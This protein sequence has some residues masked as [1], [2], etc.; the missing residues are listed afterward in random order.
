MKKV[1]L[2]AVIIH[3]CIL[4]H[5]QEVS[6]DEWQSAGQ[7]FNWLDNSIWVRY[8]VDTDGDIFWHTDDAIRFVGGFVQIQLG[9]AK[10]HTVCYYRTDRKKALVF[11][12]PIGDSVVWRCQLRK[13]RAGFELLLNGVVFGLYQKYK[14]DGEIDGKYS[15]F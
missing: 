8:S 9:G 13:S 10:A 11:I 14:S 1:V 7:D 6:A 12:K 3:V 15:P 2:L 4:L 5:G